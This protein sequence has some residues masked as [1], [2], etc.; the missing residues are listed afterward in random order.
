MKPLHRI[1]LPLIIIAI[2][3]FLAPLEAR[4]IVGIDGLISGVPIVT[5]KG[6][7]IALLGS[8]PADHDETREFQAIVN[9]VSDIVHIAESL[10]VNI[11]SH[12]VRILLLMD[13]KFPCRDLWRCF[14]ATPD[15][16]FF[17]K[18]EDEVMLQN[19]CTNAMELAKYQYGLRK[20]FSLLYGLDGLPSAFF[21][22]V[23]NIDV[24]QTVLREKINQFKAS[25]DKPLRE[26]SKLYCASGRACYDSIEETVWVPVNI[27]KQFHR[28]QG[29]INHE[30]GHHVFL[31]IS[32]R[33]VNQNDLTKGLSSGCIDLLKSFH[34]LAENELFADYMVVSNRNTNI[35]DISCWKGKPLS[36]EQKRYFSKDRTL[37]EFLADSTSNASTSFFFVEDHNILNPIR[38]LLW[39]LKLKLGLQ[40]A[41]RIMLGAIEERLKDFFLKDISTY[42]HKE[43]STFSPDA[44]SLEEY[45]NDIV[46]SNQR[47]YRCLARVA[48]KIL[49]P[50]QKSM[51]DEVSKT[52]MGKYR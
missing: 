18:L 39:H 4:P 36:D 41:N 28:F 5:Q 50:S 6:F 46:S 20:K 12:P 40:I 31:V 11:S 29:A 48:E 17:S 21:S 44:F 1:I 37:E 23:G 25:L 47:F 14:G 13:T 43:C 27:T 15:D 22:K 52:V 35:I 32:Q 3:G 10:G 2:I 45:P 30:V 49:S 8:K 24:D 16:T 7:T 42:K 33:V 38:T 51:F 9:D 26:C 34:L 19:A